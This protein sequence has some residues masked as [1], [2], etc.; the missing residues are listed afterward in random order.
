M[1]ITDTLKIKTSQQKRALF[2]PDRWVF[3]LTSTSRIDDMEI[4]GAAQNAE[5]KIRHGTMSS[6]Y[7]I[8]FLKMFNSKNEFV[9]TH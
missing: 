3:Q 1:K 8:P 2:Q 6:P 9:L 5:G 7:Q 4:K